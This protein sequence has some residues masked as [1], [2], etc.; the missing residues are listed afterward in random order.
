MEFVIEHIPTTEAYIGSLVAL[1]DNFWINK[2]A[3]RDFNESWRNS[4]T[5]R[6]LSEVSKSFL[7]VREKTY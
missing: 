4:N 7:E 6:S 1:I 2:D 5:G 3:A